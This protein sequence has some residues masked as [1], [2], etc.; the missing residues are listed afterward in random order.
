MGAIIHQVQEILGWFI[1][2][3]IVLF[4]ILIIFNILRKRPLFSRIRYI[5]ITSYI[6]V[7]M[8]LTLLPLVPNQPPLEWSEISYNLHPFETIVRS[9][10]HDYFVVGIR[11]IVGNIV[12]LLPLGLLLKLNGH[13]RAVLIGFSISLMIE[14][15]QVVLT[16]LG[17][18]LPRSFDIDDL[19]LNTLGL[20]IGYLFGSGYR[21][22]RR[23]TMKDR[24][25][26]RN[27]TR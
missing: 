22:L 23:H 9:V 12:L 15:L 19:I 5:V 13:L 21:W 20:Y 11:N 1:L 27:R 2:G 25:A 4:P 17:S 10:Q 7:I 16:K 24:S 8:Q 18:I 3:F 26:S 6:L 14:I